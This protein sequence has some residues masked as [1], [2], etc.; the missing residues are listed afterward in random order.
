MKWFARQRKAN[1]AQA[2]RR[3]RGAT[4]PPVRY[5]SSPL[6]ASK[7][8]MWRSRFVLV[9][10]GLGFAVLAGRAIYIQ[11]LESQFYQ[12]QGES[13]Y[14][15]NM[16]LPA[17]R[18]RI[19]DRNHVVLAAS[20]PAPSIYAVPKSMKASPEQ[21]RRL[22][23]LLGMPGNELQ[24]RLGLNNNYVWLRRQL[25]EDR[26]KAVMDLKLEGVGQV[27]EFRRRYPEGETSAQLVGR[28]DIQE[29]GQ[30]G[31]ELAFDKRLVGRSGSR[32]VVVDRIGRVVEDSC[33]RVPPTD[34]E[35]I[36]LSVDNRVQFIAFDR[37]R[38]GVQAH[39]AKAGSVVVLDAHSGEVLAL[40]NYP[41]YTPGERSNL[42][43]AELR[44][45]ALTDTFE[46]G[47]TMKP[48]IVGLAL[49]TGRVKPETVIQTGGGS[50]QV[51]GST[52]HD[53]HPLGAITVEQVIQKS[54]NV[55]VSKIALQMPAREMHDLYTSLGFGQKPQINFP[56]LA[57]GRLRPY[58][59]WRPIEQATMSYGYGL[60]VSLFQLARAYT[61]FANDGEVIPATL[62]HSDQPV[63]GVRLF[64][65]AVARRVRDMLRLAAGPGGTAPKAQT[66][67][68]SVGGKTGTAHK[69]E[70]GSGSYNSG[71][72]RSWFV[73]LAPIHNPRII[74]AVMVDEPSNGQY[75]GGEVA[76]PVF[77]EIVQSTLTRLGVAP[78]IE[79]KPQI[80]AQ[81]QNARGVEESF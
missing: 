4:V 79:T 42:S 33:E 72:Y 73:G 55:G 39:K 31:I 37:I 64:S 6:L 12:D 61:V 43:A 25:D 29:H 53:S 30:E 66:P 51:T 80:V 75:Y 32:C 47:S 48:L 35:D 22:A 49:E 74:V 28:T 5:A 50:W 41:S 19:L 69:Q 26:A 16:E 58:K 15:R 20:V 3:S 60:S 81:Q 54:S 56:G 67:S 38:A 9:L 34:G 10:V 14:S 36:Q 52:I 11:A 62:L 18:G 45:R 70:G 23:Q 1:M 71:K 57:Q 63:A 24:R 7:T 44:N 27:R 78:D 77:S 65:P 40:A 8:P 21:L 68:Y 76:A 17:S 13:R 2:A 46:P 59:S